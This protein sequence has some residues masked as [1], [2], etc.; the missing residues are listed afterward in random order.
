M[1]AVMEHHKLD[2]ENRTW[3]VF[4]SKL[5]WSILFVK[6]LA[7]FLV[8]TTILTKLFMPFLDTFVAV[9]SSNPYDKFW[10][11]GLTDSFPYPA[12]M[13]YIQSSPLM[14]FK[15]MGFSTA[16]ILAY[17]ITQILAD[18]TILIVLCRWLRSNIKAV[19][20]L[21]WASP[22]LFYITYLHGQL[23]VIAMALAFLSLFFLFSNKPLT[24]AFLL[25]LGIAAKLHLLLVAPFVLVFIW[26]KD[27]H[28]L[29]LI[30]FSA[31]VSFVFVFI[32]IQYLFTD[33]FRNIVLLNTEQKKLFQITF[34][35]GIDSSVFYVVPALLLMLI[36]YSIII[37]IRN[38]DLLLI[39]LGSAFGVILLII[40]PAPGWYFWIF[41]FSVY[42]FAQFERR[43]C[44]PLI[45]LQIAY[46]LYFAVIPNSDFVTVFSQNSETLTNG[47][48]L[49]QLVSFGAEPELVVSLAFSFLQTNLLILSVIMLYRGVHQPQRSKARARPLMIG[50]A[51][52]S[53]AGKTT[54]ADG[55]VGLFGKKNARVICGDDM[56]K[57][58]RGDQQWSQLT[59]LNPLANELHAELDF[60]KRLRQNR[61]VYRRHYDHDTGKFTEAKPIRPCSVLI[62]E[63]LHSFYLRPARNLFDLKIFVKPNPDL[64][65][66]RK[67][68]RDVSKRGSSK[69]KTIASVNSRRKDSKKYIITQEKHADLIVSFF[70]IEPIS[71]SDIGKDNI[72]LDERLKLTLSN[73]Y[74]VGA[75]V[76]SMMEFM[77]DNIRHIY[78]DNDQQVIEFDAPPDIKLIQFLGARHIGGFEMLSV[79]APQWSSDW[80]GL[81]Q[82]F[83][84]Y[85]VFTDLEDRLVQ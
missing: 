72:K 29:H 36:A 18:I 67:I 6:I 78:D 69:E 81:L 33:G 64:L 1:K 3:E 44:L 49:N 15:W 80:D 30:Q 77:P 58:Q 84:S 14:V 39:F 31:V 54:L 19:L 55:I 53:G 42:F 38:R 75:I 45:M 11:R 41:P 24:A 68:L 60:L 47:W 65:L 12:A 22:V 43:Y 57:W 7:I 34:E 50:I 79:Y 52:D 85:L 13:L 25:G 9:P 28:F 46:I 20:W 71:K 61:I 70:S 63:G 23:D 76:S 10:L 26:Q 5:F 17:S 21:Y 59:H 16:P 62:V 35:T 66:H 32:N 56:H 51:G 73:R 83:I 37:Q 2:Y 82:L 27:R 4:R 8:D 48:V 40:P 74:Y